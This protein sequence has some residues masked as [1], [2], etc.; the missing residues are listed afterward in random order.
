MAKLELENEEIRRKKQLLKDAETILKKEFIGIDSVI[1]QTLFNMRP[2]YLYPE[3]QEKPLVISLVGLTGTGKTSLVKRLVQLLDIE[4]DMVYFNFAEIND[5]KPWEVE[6][7]IDEQLSN[8][9]SNRVFVY[10]EFQY[11][12]T[13]DSSGGEKDNRSGLKPF[14]ELMDSVNMKRLNWK[15]AFGLTRLIVW[16][17]CQNMMSKS[18]V[19]ISIS[20]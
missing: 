10:D 12:A 14:W 2:W 6:D 17:G 18:S 15:T 20:M 16:L 3:L 7:T 13:L 4:N 5:M 11:A 9:K 1:E 19:G 8:E